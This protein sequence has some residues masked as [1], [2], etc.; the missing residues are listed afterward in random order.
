MG[1][2]LKLELKRRVLDLDL[3]GEKYELRFPTQGQVDS[4]AKKALDYIDGKSKKSENQLVRE[5]L[6]EMGL[7]QKICKETEQEHVLEIFNTL[8]AAKKK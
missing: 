7:P 2:T 8:T 5:F 1:A 6:E 3:Y 4:H